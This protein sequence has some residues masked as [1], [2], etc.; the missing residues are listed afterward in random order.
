MP[1]SSLSKVLIISGL[2]ALLTAPAL[3]A[4]PSVEKIPSVLAPWIGWVLDDA[5]D[6]QCTQVQGV[7]NCVWPSNLTLDADTQGASFTLLVATDRETRVVL[8]GSA[9]QWPI[10]VRVGREPAVVIEPSGMPE[11]LLPA[12]AHAIQGRFAWKEL[13][14]SLQLPMNLG[15]LSLS[16]DGK[17]VG[18][19]KR[20][21][22]GLLW[23]A[24]GRGQ[25]TETETLE[26]SVNR[27]IDDG[28]PMRITTRIQVAASGTTRE[29]V[30]PRVLVEGTR[31]IELRAELPAQL[32]ADGSLRMQAQAGS[33]CV[34][35]IAI[36]EGPVDMLRAPKAESPWPEREY[37]VFA[38][39]DALRHV[40]LPATG[41]IDPSRTD[42]PSEWHNLQTYAV[43]PG[44][45][46]TLTTRR[47]GEPEPP[48]NELSL[49]RSMWLDLDGQGYTVRDDLTGAM[50]RDFRLDLLAGVLGH[51]VVDGRDELVTSLKK[52][53]GIELRK[54]QLGLHAEW[55]M[56]STT[57]DL[58]AVGWSEDMRNL[59]TRLHL[60]P[61][62][63]LLGAE[64]VDNI[65]GTWIDRWDLW[66][67]FFVLLVALAMAKLAGPLWGLLA[68][69]T[70]VLCHH[71]PG[72][73]AAVWLWL[74]AATALLRVVQA[75]RWLTVARVTW[76]LGLLALLS[77]AV[78]FSV[79]QLRKALYPQLDATAQMT[80]PEPYSDTL[81]Q[82]AMEPAEEQ[83]EAA[84]DMPKAAPVPVPMPESL[85][86][87]EGARGKAAGNWM[88]QSLSGNLKGRSQPKGYS[89]YEQNDVDPQSVVQ[90]GPGVPNWQFHEAQLTWSGPVQRDQRIKLWLV[91]PI[92]LRI[93]SLLT[94]LLTFAL[95]LGLA[96]SARSRAKAS[97]PAPPV[98]TLILLLTF[99]PSNSAH[100][101]V[102]PPADVLES[103]K[104]KLLKPAECEPSCVSVPQLALSIEGTRLTLR[105]EVH[106]GSQAAYQAPG[107]L[108]SWA[109]DS[110]RVDGDPALA[111]VRL[112][113]GFLYVRVS[114]GRHTVELSGNLPRSQS[115]TLALGTPPHH[116]QA[117]A[118]GFVIEGLRADGRAEG[119]LAL[120]REVSLDPAQGG[121]E[122]TLMQ[123]LEVRRSFNLGVRFRVLTTL[124]RLG[125]ANE[126]MLVRLPLLPG[127]SV[128]EAGLSSENG[129]VVIELGRDQSELT[130][131]STL[132]VTSNIT[133]VAAVPTD[134]AQGAVIRPW[135]ETWDIACAP[136]YHCSFDGL[137]PITR[138][139]EGAFQPQYRP[140]P[141][142]KL[143]VKAERLEGAPG[144]SVTIDSASL[145][146]TPG[147]R[148][149]QG[150][151]SL[152][153]RAS[154]GTTERITLPAQSTLSSLTV[155]GTART[156]R[157]K[158]G[159]VELQ[160]DPGTHQVTLSFQRPVGMG[161]HYTSPPVR[162][163]QAL[164]NV[165]TSLSIPS[166]R[167]L[168]FAH[169]PSWG[170]AILF[171]GYLLLIVVL[172]LG[173]GKVPTSPLKSHEWVLLGLGLTQIEA[174]ILLVIIGWFFALAYREKH[175]LE[176]RWAFNL[177]Q[178]ALVLFSF[179]ALSCL[180][181]AVRQGLVVQPD[182]QVQGMN[183]TGAELRWYVDRSAGAFPNVGIVSLPL[184]VYKSLM[185]LWA[186]WLAASL[187]RWLRW[188][189]HSFSAGGSWRSAPARPKS[190]QNPRVPHEQ[191][192]ATNAALAARKR[193]GDA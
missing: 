179:V 131:V 14:D 5:G 66:D 63:M 39:D 114:P 107:P 166:D 133:L 189:F 52:A 49:V 94:V 162:V 62:F 109:P 59:T 11:M 48:P 7:R 91:P 112:E 187:L 120:R 76:V 185:L 180:S 12:G 115:L 170:P 43:T 88:Q 78:P 130:F 89:G 103:L 71:E 21:A 47:R 17:R 6:A 41:Q 113:D 111:A 73:P 69:C 182:M 126:T 74:L 19:P 151:I 70:L 95:L 3:A 90:T 148:I 174:P 169:G 86:D 136:L 152:Q 28:V 16:I 67:F 129:S 160:L 137:S 36:V 92:A 193:E 75:P 146:V 45:G 157:I 93:W 65:P 33:Y 79:A 101:Q 175:A 99:A 83:N 108:D 53:N 102:V 1:H 77:V 10:E 155:D 119:S 106:A 61:G 104:N 68:L 138:L 161:Q 97:I 80:S 35:I 44:T 27:R 57:R 30:L 60:P 58:P 40:E 178:I 116:V 46:L 8:P 159:R 87:A 81:I 147:T 20:E 128:T 158:D 118:P 56:D 135:S 72:A 24:Q 98:A 190:P 51:A 154:R 167:W 183:S 96:R 171:W 165:T 42:L 13:P 156:A 176:A 145:N 143:T 140:W 26:L 149:E 177:G 132:P 29:V 184:W 188:G 32:A 127:E 2:L 124:K 105:A 34:E 191:I 121:A 163:G 50:H 100:A 153:V 110:V 84:L 181:Y 134:S 4:P 172:A 25:E 186:L 123:W 150:A 54:G 38:A 31:A 192:E 173:L 64:G 144:S 141:G 18:S 15:T 139:V 117:R 122:Q 125:P 164:T 37:W 22:N 168:L 142:E 82:E 55:R 85:E 23:L 9:E